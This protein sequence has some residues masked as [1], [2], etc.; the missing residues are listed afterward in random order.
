MFAETNNHTFEIEFLPGIHQR[1]LRNRVGMLR[2]AH[3]ANILPLEEY[4]ALQPIIE[5][6]SSDFN[7]SEVLQNAGV[8]NAIENRKGSIKDRELYYSEELW[9]KGKTLNRERAVLACTFAHLMAMR[10]CVEDDFDV[11]LEDNVRMC[12]DF[13]ACAERIALRRNEHENA[14]D[15]A[16]LLYFGWLGSIRNLKWVIHTHAKKSEFDGQNTFSFPTVEDTDAYNANAESSSSNNNNV[17]GTALWGAYAYH[18]N[19]KA[20][21]ALISALRCDVGSLLWKGKRM[22]SYVAKPI[23]KIMPRRVRAAGLQVRVVKQP[24]FFRAPMLTS[25]IHSQWDAEF[26]KSTEVQLLE[27]GVFGNNNNSGSWD[28]LWLTDEESCVVMY[29]REHDGVWLSY[30]DVIANT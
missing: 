9:R 3:Q 18:I 20:Y 13:V 16:D 29:Q 25:R 21:N 17:G 23:D 7:I 22:R 6:E 27:T 19:R 28:G 8:V 5:S 10:R 12:R 11:I 30:P 4:H 24:V 26:C 14:N 15:A 1:T 2:C